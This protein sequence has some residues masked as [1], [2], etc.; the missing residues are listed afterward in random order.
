M[1]MALATDVVRMRIEVLE[2]ESPSR[3]RLDQWIASREVS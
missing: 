3:R 2:R 1:I